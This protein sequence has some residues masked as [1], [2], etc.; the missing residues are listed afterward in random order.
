M[1]AFRVHE[2]EKVLLV[3]ES[4]VDIVYDDAEV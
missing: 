1:D 4:I 3:L 2:T